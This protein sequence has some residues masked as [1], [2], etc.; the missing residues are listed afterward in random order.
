[1]IPSI[2]PIDWPLP[3]LAF[4]LVMLG[5]GCSRPSEPSSPQ[6]PLTSHPNTSAASQS[7][8]KSRLGDLTAL[9]DLAADTASLVQEGKLA[10]ARDHIKELELAWDSAEAGLKPRAPEDWHT[11]DKAIDRALT[12]LRKQDPSQIECEAAMADLLKTFAQ[13]SE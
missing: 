2:R 11:L 12:L 3:T 10:T 4:L 6:M 5:A 8:A 13:L 1:M 7:A 9:R